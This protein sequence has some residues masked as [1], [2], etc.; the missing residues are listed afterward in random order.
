MKTAICFSG[1]LRSVDA[2][3]QLIKTNVYDS[4]HNPDVFIHLWEDDPNLHKIKYLTDNMNVVDIKMEPRQTFDEKDYGVNKRKEVNVQGLLRQ[5][6]CVQQCNNLKTAFEKTNEMT[7]DI[8]CR[9]RPDILI[10]TN[11]KIEKKEY[12]LSKIYVPNHDS[13]YGRNDRLYFGSSYNMDILSNRI[14][15][16]DFYHKHK[17]VIHYETFMMFVAGLHEIEFEYIPLRFGLLRDNGD[18]VPPTG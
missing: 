8:V 10:D 12:D 3:H 18:Y 16:L 1:E 7:Y 5:I 14:E 11:T 6:Y 13:W 15:H 9:I 17:G 2:T 4:F